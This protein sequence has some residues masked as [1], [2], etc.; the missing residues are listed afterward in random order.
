GAGNQRMMLYVNEGLKL[1]ACSPSFVD[2]RDGIIQAATIH[3]GG[4]DVCRLWVAFARFGLG[5]DA[6]PGPFY[7]PL[8]PVNG[9]SVPKNCRT[10]TWSKDKPWDT[11][12]EPDAATA[13]DD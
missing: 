6:N 8:A 13:N 11:G 2:A 1:T 9:F 12:A 5:T 3:Y 10:D 4:E 7:A